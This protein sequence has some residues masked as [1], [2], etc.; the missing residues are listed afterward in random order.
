MRTPLIYWGAHATGSGSF[1]DG[2]THH[3]FLTCALACRFSAVHTA[4]VHHWYLVVGLRYG[5]TVHMAP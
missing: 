4:L 3:P 1:P 5:H 2:G